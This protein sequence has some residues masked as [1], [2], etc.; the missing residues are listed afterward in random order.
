LQILNVSLLD[1][2]TLSKLFE[3]YLSQDIKEQKCIN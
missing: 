1:K 2:T 3:N